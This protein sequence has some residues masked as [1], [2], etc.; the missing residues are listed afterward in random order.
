[1]SKKISRKQLKKILQKCFNQVTE[2]GKH[3]DEKDEV[4][5]RE[6]YLAQIIFD[7]SHDYKN[8][9]AVGAINSYRTAANRTSL[10]YY[11]D[12]LVALGGM[13]EVAEKLGFKIKSKERSKCSSATAIPKFLVLDD[14]RE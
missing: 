10:A 7:M 3:M 14:R 9:P 13:V 4:C 5:L 2:I 11:S 6:S 12:T 1:M 8:N